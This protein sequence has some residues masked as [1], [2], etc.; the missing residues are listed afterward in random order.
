MSARI[1]Y[2]RRGTK[3]QRRDTRDNPVD[4]DADNGVQHLSPSAPPAT[5]SRSPKRLQVEVLIPPS[6]FSKSP[7]KSPVKFIPPS[8]NKGAV[9][10]SPSGTEA[11][12]LV[13]KKRSEVRNATKSFFR[14]SHS[15]RHGFNTCES[16]TLLADVLPAIPPTPKRM[17]STKSTFRFTSED[18][19][20]PL[21]M[22]PRKS[23]S[24]SKMASTPTVAARPSTSKQPSTRLTGDDATLPT[25][26][27]SGR[28][29]SSK[30]IRDNVTPVPS[31][32]DKSL[33]SIVLQNK[34]DKA[35]ARKWPH[36]PPPSLGPSLPSRSV[37]AATAFLPRT[38]LKAVASMP[39]SSPLTPATDTPLRRTKTEPHTSAFSDLFDFAQ[40]STSARMTSA[41]GSPVI[42]MAKRMLA[43]TRTEPTPDTGASALQ[44]LISSVSPNV[45]AQ[46]P[47][48]ATETQPIDDT[49]SLPSAPPRPQA[50]SMVQQSNG[51]RTYAGHSRS[52]LQATSVIDVDDL[53]API[54]ESYT[55]LRV[56]WGVDYSDP[57]PLLP[58]RSPTPS[59]PPM[60][61]GSAKGRGSGEM[62]GKGGAKSR[63]KG[64][65][66]E[67]PK[68]RSDLAP[69]MMNDVRSITELRTKGEARRFMD[70][71]GY[72]FEG[73]GEDASIGVRRGSALEIVTKLCDTDFARRAK[74]TDFLNRAWN[75]LRMA[76]AGD[77]DRVL[78]AILVVFA[79]LA[80]QTPGD[81]D[82][83]AREEG[84]V[85]VMCE[86]LTS[87]GRGR[88]PLQAAAREMSE[89]EFRKI[90]LGKPERLSL[91]A[92][93][94]LLVKKSGLTASSTV[95]HLRELVSL[96]LSALSPSLLTSTQFPCLHASLLLEL[97]LLPHRLSAYS[98]GL[99]LLPDTN[100]D[101]APSLAH[102]EH[103]LSAVDAFLLGRWTEGESVQLC[104]DVINGEGQ[105]ELCRGLVALC[106]ISH[107]LLWTTQD[108]DETALASKCLET[109]LRVLINLSHDNKPWC[110]LLLAEARTVPLMMSLL[111]E[112]DARSVP[113]AQYRIG[114]TL[115][116]AAHDHKEQAFD[117]LCLGLGLLTNLVQADDRAM[118][119]VR[120]TSLNPACS[121]SRRCAHGCRCVT[122]TEAL[123]ILASLYACTHTSTTPSDTMLRA[124]LAILLGLLMRSPPNTSSLLPLLPGGIDALIGYVGEFGGLYEDFLGRVAGREEAEEGEEEREGRAKRSAGDGVARDVMAFLNG[125][126]DT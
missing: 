104:D 90:G 118:D 112:Y 33:S 87:V 92:L 102:I 51:I 117:R 4:S 125:L 77:G 57:D 26:A 91:S 101:D 106:S 122:R 110:A 72:L 114:D 5:P 23:P 48:Q 12:E 82:G 21:D 45:L 9:L 123:N 8:P 38:P 46:D 22:L 65:P 56:R 29:P 52:F 24:S 16:V 19:E 28:K 109:T 84:F 103:C 85:H 67:I 25:P 95:P 40:P 34:L 7:S 6:P 71:V 53:D 126:R 74:A 119:I 93:R 55:D 42:P 107:I 17:E 124:H 64:K 100:D 79:A 10:S 113:E 13:E 108:G 54:P 39:I 36:S 35:S 59:T 111:A 88:D 68:R 86:M 116:E 14:A 81:L 30:R 11:V 69:N 63:G 44:S 99:P 60:G 83:L 1:T 94:T 62:K 43:R 18:S 2:A 49:D 47:S 73:M 31:G 121:L 105:A 96:S 15:L 32:A 27:D 98:T 41:R 75:V 89:V 97:S 115:D 120:Q 37:V 70:E 80:A 78:N 50:G 58:S 61:Y 20:D 76:G 3:R 66:H